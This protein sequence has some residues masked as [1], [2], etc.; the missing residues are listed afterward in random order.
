MGEGR[1]DQMSGDRLLD[2]ERFRWLP[3]HEVAWLEFLLSRL[4]LGKLRRVWDVGTRNCWFRQ[5]TLPLANL[6]Q[7]RAEFPMAT[8]A[9]T[10]SHNLVFSS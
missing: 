2:V 8:M 7:L 9:Q 4:Y 1:G 6:K 10:F 5:R 3:H